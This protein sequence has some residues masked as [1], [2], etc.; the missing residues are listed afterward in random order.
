[1]HAEPGSSFHMCAYLLTFGVGT[2]GL[3]YDFSKWNYKD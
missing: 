2:F 3:G 1:M